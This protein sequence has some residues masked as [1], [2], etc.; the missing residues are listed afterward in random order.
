MPINF[1]VQKIKVTNKL[2]KVTFPAAMLALIRLQLISFTV[3]RMNDIF[4]SGHSSVI[5]TVVHSYVYD[6]VVTKIS[7]ISQN[8]F[9]LFA[10]FIQKTVKE[11][12]NYFFG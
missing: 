9:S 10:P 1:K 7:S 11:K 8:V 4:F 5:H 12:E 2:D 6:E 3:T